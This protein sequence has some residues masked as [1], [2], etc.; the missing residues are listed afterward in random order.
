VCKYFVSRQLNEAI[1]AASKFVKVD[2]KIPANSVSVER[3]FSAAKI[4][5]AYLPSLQNRNK[6]L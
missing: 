2:F 4:I 3:S 1:A 6:L 5:K